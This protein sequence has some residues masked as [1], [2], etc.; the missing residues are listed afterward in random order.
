MTSTSLNEKRD[1]CQ[2]AKDSPLRVRLVPGLNTAALLVKKDRELLL[3]YI[4]RA[5]DINGQGYTKYDESLGFL[6]NRLG[7]S[8]RTLMRLFR[9]G[10][11]IFWKRCINSHSTIKIYALKTVAEYFMT[12]EM[13]RFVDMAIVDIP[14]TLQGRRGM[15]YATAAYQPFGTTHRSPIS[16][17]SLGEKTGIEPRQQ[18]RYDTASNTVRQETKAKRYDPITHKRYSVKQK[19]TGANGE[20]FEQAKQLG[21]IYIALGSRSR[22]GQLKKVGKA[23]RRQLG[24]LLTAGAHDKFSR[25]YYG[26]FQTFLKRYLRG[27][28]PETGCYYPTKTNKA[29]LIECFMANS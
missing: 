6:I 12:Y 13:G 22:K 27:K 2:Y 4:I 29:V 1:N 16:R 14:E 21:N 26:T 19:L 8:R 17:Q 20:Q 3:W 5:L 23:V 15:L 7:Y 24:S 11:G 25:R 9:R 28:A 10:E 18:R